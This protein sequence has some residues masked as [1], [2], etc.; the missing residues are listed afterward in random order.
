MI[1]IERTECPGILSDVEAG[2]TRYNAKSV[3]IALHRMQHGKCCYCEEKIPEGGHLKAVEHFAPKSVFNDLTNDWGNLLLACAQ[4]NGKKS[5]RF[6]V[7]LSDENGV[8]AV[9]YIKEPSEGVRLL[10]NPCLDDPEEHLEFSVDFN[11]EEMG[12]ISE[13]GRS[14]MGRTTIDVVGL[15]GVFYTKARRRH[16]RMLA[17]VYLAVLSAL[18][19]GDWNTADACP[20]NLCQYRNA[21]HRFCACSRAFISGTKIEERV[22]QIKERGYM[23]Q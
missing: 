22:R 5:D 18:D 1:R 7:M 21:Q 2:V 6:P 14:A 9:V 10:I 8:V 20:S 15:D 12:Q 3:V 16:L 13:K 23:A 4:C 19:E 17:Q 11:A